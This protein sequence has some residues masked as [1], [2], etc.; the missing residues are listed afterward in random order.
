MVRWRVLGLLVLASAIAYLFRINVSIAGT[1]MAADFG[2]STA[3][4]GLVLGAFAWSYGL[5]Q[6]P[7]GILGEVGGARRVLGWGMAGW[8]VVTALMVLVPGPKLVPTAVSLGLLVAVRVVLG[9]LQAPLYPLTSGSVISRWFPPSSWGLPNGLSTT[10]LTL[11]AAAAGP[12]LAWLIGALGWRVG[13]LVTAPLAVGVAGV[14]WWYYRDDPA[15]H[16]G[17]SPAELV[18]IRSEGDSTPAGTSGLR[19]V[20]LNRDVLSITF[21]YFCINY[22]FYLFFNWFFYYLT[23]VRKLPSQVG[24]NFVGAQWIVGAITATLGGV[25]CDRLSARFGPRIGCG[26]VVG[27]SALLAAP[28]LVAGALTESPV[29]AVALL[30]VS[31]GFTQLPDA[32]YWTAAMRVAGPHAPAATG[33]MNT[34]GNVVGGVG[35]LL[36]PLVAASFGWVV[37]ISTGAIFAVLA[38]VPWLWIRTDRS[39]ADQTR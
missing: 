23:E 21:S 13:L 35:A 26:A 38:A 18:L 3:Q 17:V 7:A 39:M 2:L 16:A 25:L 4:L 14:W 22:V 9:A 30:S 33:A 6:I 34:G 28:F 19:A 5:L 15:D 31:F 32:A 24:G 11:G 29:A 27:G 8:G 10:G 12:L 20:L 36:V 37:A 1:A